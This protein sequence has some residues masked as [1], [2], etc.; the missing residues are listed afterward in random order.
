MVKVHL[1]PEL[2]ISPAKLADAIC[3]FYPILT[4]KICQKLA[5]IKQALLPHDGVAREYV[6]SFKQQCAW[7]VRKLNALFN[8]YIFQDLFETLLGQ[9]LSV[10]VGGGGAIQLDHLHM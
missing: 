4:G 1:Q 3:R 5:K 9:Q 7:I 6:L 8:R 10:C 2:A